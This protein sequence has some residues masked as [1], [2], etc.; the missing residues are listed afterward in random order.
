MAHVANAAGVMVVMVMAR[1]VVMARLSV[2]VMAAG[3]MAAGVRGGV[4]ARRGG[5]GVVVARGPGGLHRPFPRR[6][7]IAAGLRRGGGGGRSGGRRR[8][9]GLR[10]SR[11]GEGR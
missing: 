2:V 11:R 8:R 1:R 3:V 5:L 6:G 4:A 7:L 10:D 9:R